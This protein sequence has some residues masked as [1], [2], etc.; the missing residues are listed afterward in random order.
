MHGLTDT[1]LRTADNDNAPPTMGDVIAARLGRRDMMK[2]LMAATA[3]GLLPI[4]AVRSITRAAHANERGSFTFSEISHGVDETH[5]VAPGYDADVLIRWGDPVLANAP[6]FNPMKQTATAQARQFGYNNDYI[7]FIPLSSDGDSALLCIN[8][9]YTNPEVMFPGV[10]PDQPKLGFRDMT[11]ELVDIEMAAHGVSIVEIRKSNGKWR[12]VPGSRYSRRITAETPIRISGPATGHK[13][14]RTSYDPRGVSVRG[15]INNCAGGVTAWGTYLACEENFNNYFS[16]KIAGHAEEANYKSYGVP[17]SEYA[18]SKFHDRFDIGKEPNEANR[19]GWV[20]EIDALDPKAPPV[21]RTALG[22]YKHEGAEPIVNK[23][24]RVVIYSGDD[25]RFA[26]LYKFVSAGRYNPDD[27]AANRN[28]LDSGT[29]YVAKFSADG[30]MEWLPLVHGQGPLTAANGFEGQA[31]VLIETRRAATLLGATP[32]DR[33]EDVEPSKVTD[34]IYVVLTNNDKRTA[35]QRDA[36]NPRA[37][38]QWGHIVEL[39]APDGDHAA[40]R[41]TWN[42]LIKGGDPSKREIGALWN[43]ATSASGWFSCPDNCAV[44][45]QGRLWIATDQGAA[46][47]KASGTADGVWAI[48]T[49]GPLR[50]TAR[51]FFRVP[52]GAEMCGPAFAPDNKTFFCAVQHPAVDGAAAFAPFGRSSTFADP[53]TRWPDFDPAMPV[54]PSVVVVTKRDGGVIGS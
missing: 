3:L 32:M 44:D 34:N 52:V 5:H 11:K 8:H 42:I 2:G 41:Y 36:V 18:W 19:F 6:R 47:K 16:G 20:V 39:T 9:E 10:A 15:T 40:T 35:I 43:P 17:A 27:R 4:G 22:R 1:V 25:E 23:D 46:W 29:L 31:D 50:G 13:R 37:E 14:L 24:G 45:N 38:N 33:P 51:M 49:A 28:I 30:A 12:I 21:K 53:A 7:G 48:E 54:R 26:F